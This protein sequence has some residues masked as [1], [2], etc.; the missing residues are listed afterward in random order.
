M[1]RTLRSFNSSPSLNKQIKKPRNYW[2]DKNHQ[3]Q[4]LEGLRS[5]LGLNSVSEWADIP[6]KVIVQ[7]GGSFLFKKYSSF[8]GALKEIYP[9]ENWQTSRRY[10]ANYWLS[11]ANVKEFLKEIESK[12]SLKKVEDWQIVSS[13]I[14]KENGGSGL[15]Q[16]NPSLF[17]ILTDVFP[18][19]NWWKSGLQFKIPRKYWN[20][21]HNQRKFMD[22]LCR[23]LQLHEISEWKTVSA[24]QIEECGGVRLLEIYPSMY[25]LLSSIYPEYDWTSISLPNDN[26]NSNNSPKIKYENPEKYE[27]QILSSID[28]DNENKDDPYGL[29]IKQISLEDEND[30]QKVILPVLVPHRVEQR[31]WMDQLAIKINIQSHNDWI[32]LTM[33]IVIENGGLDIA[34]EYP[35]LS[36]A[37][38]KLYPEFKWKRLYQIRQCPHEFWINHWK[39]LEN[40]KAFLNDLALKFNIKSMKDWIYVNESQVKDQGGLGILYFHGSLRNALMEVFPEKD[41][42]ILPDI[43]PDDQSIWFDPK[44]QR[45][46]FDQIAA[47]LHI[48]SPS[49]WFS[50]PIEKI[51]ALGGGKILIYYPSLLDTLKALYPEHKWNKCKKSSKNLDYLLNIENKRKFLDDI[52]KHL[53]LKTPR[54]WIVSSSSVKK[55]STSLL[56][57]YSSYYAMLRDVYPDKNWDFFLNDNTTTIPRFYWT[58]PIN[59]RSFIHHLEKVKEIDSKADWFEISQSDI[60]NINGGHDLLRLYGSLVNILQIAYPDELWVP[61]LFKSSKSTEQDKIFSQIVKA[62]PQHTIIRR[63][64]H[65]SIRIHGKKV[66]FLAYLPSIKLLVKYH[67]KY[68]Y[69]RLGLASSLDLY[70]TY[71]QEIT[72]ACKE[73]GF[74]VAIIR[75]WNCT[76]P[77]S[78]LELISNANPKLSL[79]KQ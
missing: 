23:K 3:R 48:T 44:H 69:R 66:R 25:D 56:K 38:R 30:E 31:K 77:N 32:P 74:N 43:S 75:H 67:G 9:E 73:Q 37:L 14:I 20:Y 78:L 16:I 8:E 18:E 45:S 39:N 15:L 79:A 36:A 47:A 22:K 27:K 12:L 68:D 11:D 13:R 72:T 24:R 62:F 10:P 28:T 59:V 58:D 50:V 64:S 34:K 4:F 57:M 35:T 19:K 26:N 71:D 42:S 65:D 70:N 76:T 21:I 46:L 7:N 55:L 1:F 29:N 41:W 60:C 54:D 40:Q 2:Q 61:S 5:Q 52:A 6:T 51:K 53:H 17:D 63:Y 49:E 33:D